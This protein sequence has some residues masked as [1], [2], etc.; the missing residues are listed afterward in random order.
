MD[1]QPG[2]AQKAFQ[3]L[4][5]SASAPQK[6]QKADKQKAQSS[7]RAKSLKQKKEKTKIHDLISSFC[8][9]EG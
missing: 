3:V 6:T 4:N 5:K 1:E 8:L 7:S 9:D 2:G